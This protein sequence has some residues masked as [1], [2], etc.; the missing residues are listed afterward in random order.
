[1][2]PVFEFTLHSWVFLLGVSLLHAALITMQ[3][4]SEGLYISGN[5]FREQTRSIGKAVLWGTL[6]LCF[7]YGLQGSHW[8]VVGLICLA[9][10]VHFGLQGENPHRRDF[11]SQRVD[12]WSRPSRPASGRLHQGTS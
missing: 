2:V 6:V 8:T 1:M 10:A 12:R 9:G 11:D 3:G 7:A 4:F 5:D